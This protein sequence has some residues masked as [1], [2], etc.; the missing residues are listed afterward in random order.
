MNA[1]VRATLL[2]FG[3]AY[4]LAWATNSMVAGPG[5]A[6]LVRLTGSLQLSGLYM[7]FFFMSAAVGAATAGRAM[8][9]FGRKPPIAAAY[10]VSAIGFSFAGFGATSSKIALFV[11]GV[12][13]LAA[14]FGA[15]N[16]TRM[17]AAE[18][19]PPAERGRGIAWIQISAIF[20][21]VTGPV[22]L[23]ASEPIGRAL[24]RAPL[25]L[26]WFLAPPLLICAAALAGTA[27]EPRN[28]AAPMESSPPAS[29]MS[30]GDATK[31][32]TLTGVAALAA[33]QASMAAVMGV[34]GAA[35]S[36]AGHGAGVLGGLML[37][38]FVGMFGL[39]RITGR[40]A[41]TMGRRKTI[42]MGLTLIACGGAVVALVHGALAFGV[43]LFL[44]GLG[45]SFS[46]LGATV[47]L[48]DVTHASTRA[49]TMGRADLVAQM[50]SAAVAF[51]GGLWFASHGLAGLGLVAI[52]AVAVPAALIVAL[53]EPRP[54]TYELAV[55]RP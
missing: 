53:R 9:R 31:R 46:Y 44:V 1:S 54:G 45:W 13:M 26:I 8:D 41:D 2:R 12:V 51:G 39:S 28:L 7:T 30:T 21:A 3:S 37:M 24:G 6:T 50:T 40:I 42:A 20:G 4:A 43:G 14:A 32:I 10:G 34:A 29:D 33:S 18:M 17:A 38:H 52:A 16:L 11:P 27:L 22:L 55:S 48:T 23:V 19:F 5:S 25:D 35:V 36:H 49:R 15:I 47:L